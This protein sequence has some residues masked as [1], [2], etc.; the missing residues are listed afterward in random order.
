M[1][2]SMGRLARVVSILVVLFGT[3][4]A[5]AAVPRITMALF[6]KL[7]D[8]I[9]MEAVERLLGQP[10]ETA[11]QT[12]GQETANGAWTCRIWR[13]SVCDTVDADG[14]CSRDSWGTLYE[15]VFRRE[16]TGWV[17]NS[18]HRAGR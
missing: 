4:A 13:Y 7:D 5:H 2:N 12:C 3:V 14:R 9:S 11:Q 15:I 17:V 18:W 10:V 6:N 1:G 8:G 16:T